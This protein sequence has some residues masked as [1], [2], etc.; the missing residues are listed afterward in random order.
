MTDA[1]RIRARLAASALFLAAALLGAGVHAET[2]ADAG[3]RE[4]VL[5]TL[6]ESLAT[7]P[8]KEDADL[9]TASIWRVWGDSG[10]DTVNLLMDRALEAMKK[11]EFDT[12]LL[13]L[14]EVVELEPRF[15]EGWNRRATVHFRLGYYSASVADIQHTLIL[16]PRHFGAMSGL[17]AI[18]KETGREKSAL[19]VFRR[20]LTFN[21][22]LESAS[23]AVKELSVEVEGRDI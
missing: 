22:H 11:E 18:L 8:S 19:E 10:S 14:D 21:P 9:V 5:D 20:A 6:F 23:K 7:A 12:A 3:D 2:A 4:Q 17:G 15:A 13:I 1:A 16:E